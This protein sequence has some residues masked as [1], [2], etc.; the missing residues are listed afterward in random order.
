ML[1]EKQIKKR[2]AEILSDERLS[3]R[4]ADIFT[5]APL[6]LIQVAYETE[7]HTLQEV[8]EIELTDFKKLRGEKK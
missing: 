5:N 4:T 3:Y 6:A 2:I 1:T 7:V 8:L